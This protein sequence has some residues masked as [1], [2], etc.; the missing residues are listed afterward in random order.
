MTRPQ[1]M[2]LLRRAYGAGPLHLLGHTIV[3]AISAYALSIMFRA[4]FAPEP[5]N[6]VL[7]LLGGAVLHDLVFL[8]A[9]SAVNVAARRLFGDGTAINYV[10][11][12]IIVA[13]ILLLAFLPRIAERQPG[14]FERALGHAPP[15]YLSRWLLLTALLFVGSAVIWGVQRRRHG[16]G[17]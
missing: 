2:T 11:V 16:S 12:P 8:P 4:S 14:N 17:A 9:Y 15:D 5:L 10:R 6:L 1:P 3:I 13:G 7:W